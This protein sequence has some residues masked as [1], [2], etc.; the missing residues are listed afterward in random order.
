MITHGLIIK[1]IT[2][3]CYQVGHY[4]FRVDVQVKV[5]ATDFVASGVLVTHQLHSFSET[6]IF[7]QGRGDWSLSRGLV[8]DPVP[9]PTDRQAHTPTQK[10]TLSHTLRA[11]NLESPINL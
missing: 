4:M 2:K 11:Y 8:R 7:F 9:A 6:L 5:T 1:E 3:R 10:H